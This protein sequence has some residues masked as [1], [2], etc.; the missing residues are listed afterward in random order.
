MGL[1]SHYRGD[2][3]PV[4]CTSDLD[5]RSS[6]G[7][8]FHSASLEGPNGEGLWVFAPN[9]FIMHRAIYPHEEVAAHVRDSNKKRDCVTSVI[10]TSKVA[11]KSFGADKSAPA[12]AEAI[13]DL[14][15]RIDPAFPAAAYIHGA[16]KR[17]EECCR[18][19]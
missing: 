16:N 2:S 11:E 10:H 12:L 17:K 3:V 15:L 4:I 6:G 18:N 8:I 9:Q 14:K 13:R 19:Q 5:A 7:G 1:N